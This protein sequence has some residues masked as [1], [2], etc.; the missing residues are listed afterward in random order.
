MALWCPDRTAFASPPGPPQLSLVLSNRASSPGFSE[1]P[2]EAQDGNRTSIS[3]HNEEEKLSYL[4]LRACPLPNNVLFGMRWPAPCWTQNVNVSVQMSPLLG[5]ALKV[6][7][8]KSVFPVLGTLLGL[9]SLVPAAYS[10]WSVLLWTCL[11]PIRPT[12]VTWSPPLGSWPWL[13]KGYT[14][15]HLYIWPPSTLCLSTC[16]KCM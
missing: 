16:D 11:V 13:P 12:E 14:T 2:T 3:G 4:C 9:W 6:S 1:I 15:N 7:I 8:H 5:P 10:A